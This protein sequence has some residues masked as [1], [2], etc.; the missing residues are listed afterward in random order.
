[1]TRT[2]T[3]IRDMESILH[4]TFLSNWNVLRIVRWLYSARTNRTLSDC[5][6]S[7]LSFGCFL[8]STECAVNCCYFNAIFKWNANCLMISIGKLLEYLTRTTTSTKSHHRFAMEPN[9]RH[10]TTIASQFH[11]PNSPFHFPDPHSTFPIQQHSP[12][13]CES[14]RRHRLDLIDVLELALGLG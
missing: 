8:P 10:N 7:L 11:R 12:L 6:L 9:K 5:T 4:F 14:T 1:M 2:R 13:L 3:M